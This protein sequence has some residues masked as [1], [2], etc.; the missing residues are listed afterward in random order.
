MTED[1]AEIYDQL[2]TAVRDA[3]QAL[4][5]NVVEIAKRAGVSTTTWHKVERG[6]QVRPSTY[7]ALDRVF[8]LD[9][10]QT[11]KATRSTAALK[12]WESAVRHPSRVALWQQRGKLPAADEALV[13]EAKQTIRDN[14]RDLELE[15]LRYHTER[16]DSTQPELSRFRNLFTPHHPRYAKPSFE[17]AVETIKQL[18]LP[19]LYQLRGVLDMVIQVR[20]SSSVEEFERAGEVLAEYNTLS[21]ASN[22]ALERW[23]EAK[24]SLGGESPE[25]EK[26]KV[27]FYEAEKAEHEAAKRLEGAVRG[28]APLLGN[29]KQDEEQGG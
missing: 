17:N 22:M 3:R 23:L 21:T 14:L 8:D 15:S 19:Y 4:G 9:T 2:G 11:L 7:A 12:A 28:L 1:S 24:R 6:E 27:A 10:G 29:R 16:D 26:L 18:P 25:T 13:R 5:V 20:E